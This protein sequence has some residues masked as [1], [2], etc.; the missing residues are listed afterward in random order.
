MSYL[1]RRLIFSVFTLFG[2]ALTVFLL[3][4]LL[5][6]DPARTLAGP[7]ATQ[8][9]VEAARVEFGLDRPLPEQF[10]RFVG[11]LFRGDLGTSNIS[12]RPVSED[13]AARL[14]YSARIALVT[15]TLTAV[16]GITLGVLA[17]IKPYSWLDQLISI[18]TLVGISM[19]SYWLGIML[20]IVFAVN[21]KWLPASGAER[22]ESVILPAL[23][24]TLVF[25]AIIVRMT[26]ASMMETLRE[27]YVRTARAKG[28]A[29]R[30]VIIKHALRNA[31]IPVITVLMLQMGALTG[32]AVLIETIFGWPGIGLM[33]SEAINAQDF[34]TVQGAVMVIAVVIIGI[35]FITDLLY[36]LLDPRIR[37]G[38]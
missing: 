37:L 10:L 11:G 31:L 15:V 4:R 7:I 36:T 3:L 29:E 33:I 34:P 28:L 13:I 35:N 6:G 12:K 25:M 16:V 22:P 2:V 24:L 18:G 32:G 38:K 21:L 26:R 8:E 1:L 30:L 5:P 23:T 14:P 27:N 19:P 17:A 9:Q 20:I